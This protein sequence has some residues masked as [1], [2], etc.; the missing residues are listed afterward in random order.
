MWRNLSKI[1]GRFFPESTMD[2]PYIPW[3]ILLI[4]LEGLSSEALRILYRILTGYDTNFQENFLQ[5]RKSIILGGLF[6]EFLVNYIL[7]PWRF[8]LKIVEG[9]FS[10]SLEDSHQN[11]WLILPRILYGFSQYLRWIRLRFSKE[12][13]KE[14]SPQPLKDTL[15]NP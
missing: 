15:Q 13:S 11:F 12:F 9:F 4:F 10:E 1:L 7:N 2:S 6:S 5:N 3:R 8:I 14:F